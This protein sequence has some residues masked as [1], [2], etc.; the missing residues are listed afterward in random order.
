MPEPEILL[1]GFQGF[2]HL[3]Y[4][5]RPVSTGSLYSPW[6]AC[7]YEAK[8]NNYNGGFAP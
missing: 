3:V 5:Q 4:S 1:K 8:V 2:T 7:I 6:H